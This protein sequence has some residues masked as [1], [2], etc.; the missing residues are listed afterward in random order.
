MERNF[1]SNV[2]S[3]SLQ[4][5]L[6]SVYSIFKAAFVLFCV[7]F[8]LFLSST[9]DTFLHKSEGEKNLRTLIIKKIFYLQ[10]TKR[11]YEK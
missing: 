8:F 9:L 4:P 5:Y 7:H 1:Y 2:T 6:F 10:T 11:A 3:E